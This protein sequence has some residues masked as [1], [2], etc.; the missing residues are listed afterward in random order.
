ML[1]LN[2]YPPKFVDK[3][4]RRFYQ[5][6]TGITTHEALIGKDH[7]KYRELVFDP[8]WNKKEKRKTEFGKNIFLHFSYAPSLAHFGPRFHQIWQEIFEG[9]PLDDISVIYAHRLTDSLKHLLVKK[10]PNKE[11]IKLP[12]E[13]SS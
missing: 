6:V 5:D 3:Q 11:S 1:L 4:M 7:S 10:R 8:T 2:K 13:T 12:S 9:T